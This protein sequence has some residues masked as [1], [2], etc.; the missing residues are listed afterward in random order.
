MKIKALSDKLEPYF[1]VIQIVI[2]SNPEWTAI[3]WGA[4]RLILQ[5]WYHPVAHSLSVPSDV[6]L[7]CHKLAGNFTTF[8]EKMAMSISQVAAEL[9]QY[10]EIERLYNTNIQP[11][12]KASLQ[13]VYVCLF[14][15]FQSIARV[16]TRKD[17]SKS[18]LVSVMVVSEK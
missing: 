5:V 3:A 1:E 7:R 10:E 9:P 14:Q 11:R 6:G 2:Q 18:P 16:F 17:G 4:F 13:E 12:L 15:F 8:F